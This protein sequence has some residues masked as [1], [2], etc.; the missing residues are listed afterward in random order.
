MKWM[1]NSGMSKIIE[2]S[3][4][5]H[6]LS[7]VNDVLVM[8]STHIILKIYRPRFQKKR[9]ILKKQKSVRYLDRLKVSYLSSFSRF[10]RPVLKGEDHEIII[11]IRTDFPFHHHPL[12]PVVSLFISM[13]ESNLIHILFHFISATNLTPCLG[14]GRTQSLE[15]LETDWLVV[16][17]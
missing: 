2:Q 10:L 14:R 5:K 9:I 8:G 17:I 13:A 12:V 16:E 7:I 3:T 1:T 11:T 4:P 6:T 15:T